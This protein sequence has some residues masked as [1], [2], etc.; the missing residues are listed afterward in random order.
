VSAPQLHFQI[1]SAWDF[2]RGVRAAVESALGD[3]D[4]D[5][6]HAVG[7]AA[8]ELIENAIKYGT[9]VQ[10]CPSAS[11][12]M[13]LGGGI[14]TIEVTNGVG[15]PARAAMV[16]EIID[17]IMAS[18]DR[19]QLYLQRLEELMRDRGSRSRLG[20]YRIGYEAG[21][22][23]RCRFEQSVLTITATRRLP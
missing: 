22:D 7:M 10:M 15:D 2:V 8:S 12:S 21:F 9:P 4:R 1:P 13:G 19:E 16:R 14:A 6:R 5:L 18:S 3:R 17:R 11:F 20:L 23:L